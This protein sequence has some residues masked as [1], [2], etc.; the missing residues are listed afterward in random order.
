[1]ALGFSLQPERAVWV[2]V[3]AL[4]NTG[5]TVH[6]QICQRTSGK[7]CPS[8]NWILMRLRSRLGIEF[9]LW[10]SNIR[11][12]GSLGCLAYL[13]CSILQEVLFSSWRNDYPRRGLWVIGWSSFKEPSWFCIGAPRTQ[14]QWKDAAV[15]WSDETIVNE[16]ILG[17]FNWHM[18]GS[19]I[20][21]LHKIWVSLRAKSRWPSVELVVEIEMLS[22]YNKTF[23]SIMWPRQSLL[24]NHYGWQ[25]NGGCRQRL[26]LWIMKGETVSISS[27]LQEMCAFH[28]TGH[29]RLDGDQK[30]HLK[31][32][33]LYTSPVKAAI[34]LSA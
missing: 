5:L 13:I 19:Y 7:E 26:Q 34:L 2:Q 23:F 6:T 20:Y 24:G 31:V 32:T 17:Q 25:V 9:L 15:R 27:V 8:T 29:G 11:S 16:E 10:V 18:P 21:L 14:G 33:C 22:G 28:K 30:S 12:S 3:T 1:M 4:A